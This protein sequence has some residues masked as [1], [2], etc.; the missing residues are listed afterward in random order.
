[1]KMDYESYLEL[2]KNI[3]SNLGLTKVK[4]SKSYM[5]LI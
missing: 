1:M 5:E 3:L 4:D 2:E